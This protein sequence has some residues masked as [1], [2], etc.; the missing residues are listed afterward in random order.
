MNVF[1]HWD[2]DDWVPLLPHMDDVSTAGCGVK[3]TP[4][5][6]LHYGWA[7]NQPQYVFLMGQAEPVGDD[8]V[9][10]KLI[11]LSTS[12]VRN[13]GDDI[14]QARAQQREFIRVFVSYV[15]AKAQEVGSIGDDEDLAGITTAE[16]DLRRA[17]C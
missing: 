7:I 9:R 4:R 16:A 11:E 1:G 10:C 17:W 14:S 3:V 8:E 12:F 15:D 2:D 6:R 5:G 13:L